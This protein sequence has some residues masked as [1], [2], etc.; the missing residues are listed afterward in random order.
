[1]TFSTLHILLTAAITAILTGA[2]GAWRLPR[3]AW[4]RPP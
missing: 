2:V 1:M 4:S 3:P